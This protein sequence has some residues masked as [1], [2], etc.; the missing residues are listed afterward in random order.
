MAEWQVDGEIGKVPVQHFAGPPCG[1]PTF[2]DTALRPHILWVVSE[3]V[4]CWSSL[5]FKSPSGMVMKAMEILKKVILTVLLR[6][7]R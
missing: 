5:P 6:F 3:V 7:S 4:Q 1:R 2:S